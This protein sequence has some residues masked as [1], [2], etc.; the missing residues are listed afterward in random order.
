M[1]ENLYFWKGGNAS[2][3]SALK[4]FIIILLLIIIMAGGC[5]GYWY[6]SIYTP[7]QEHKAAQEAAIAKLQSDIAS[8][9]T[10]YEKSLEG[11]SIIQTLTLFE[12]INRDLFPLRLA[13]VGDSLTY[14]CDSNKCDFSFNLDDGVVATYPVLQFRG[15]AYKASPYLPKGKQAAKSG[16]QFTNILI[17]NGKNAFLK[18]YKAKKEIELS[19]C[20]EI[21]S[22]ITT[23]NSF[24]GKNPK[25][26]GRIKFI[27][28]PASTVD[29]LEKELGT[30]VHSYGLRS[31]TWEIEIKGNNTSTMDDMTDMQVILYKQP[32]RSAFLI[33]KI[34]STDK[35]LKVSGGLVCKA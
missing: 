30:Q 3:N 25:K 27:T 24:L 35:G 26:G 22:Y 21:V 16:F 6:Y 10:F 20:G 12:E 29:A 17:K 9:N 13:F 11:M 19:S 7:E 4:L 5:A 15:Q 2:G 32:Y 18:A 34:A 1:L 31:A 8:V 23:Y 33:R 14:V 28:F